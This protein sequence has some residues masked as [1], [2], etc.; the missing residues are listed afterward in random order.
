MKSLCEHRAIPMLR[1][2][3]PVWA[4]GPPLQTSDRRRSSHYLTVN[5]N[6][7]LRIVNIVINNSMALQGIMSCCY[8]VVIHLTRNL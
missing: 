7:G 5:D 3:F 1:G 2:L 8:D 6:I 4:L